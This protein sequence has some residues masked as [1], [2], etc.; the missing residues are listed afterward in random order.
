MFTITFDSN[1]TVLKTWSCKSK[2]IICAYS[3]AKKKKGQGFA[4]L[5]G[6]SWETDLWVMLGFCGYILCFSEKESARRYCFLNT[7]SWQKKTWTAM[8]LL[9]SLHLTCVK[10]WWKWDACRQGFEIHG[11]TGALL[12]EKDHGRQKK[13][14]EYLKGNPQKKERRGL[15]LRMLILV[16][17]KAKT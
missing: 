2:R 14:E 17:N 5:K 7:T 12:P 10:I 11:S 9:S 6:F 13:T 1:F 3:F 16:L 15:R 4:L 8:H